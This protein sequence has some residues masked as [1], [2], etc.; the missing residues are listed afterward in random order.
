[1]ARS[2]RDPEPQDLLEATNAAKLQRIENE[3]N[4]FVQAHLDHILARIHPYLFNLAYDPY[5]MELITELREQCRFRIPWHDVRDWL[6][7]ISEGAGQNDESEKVGVVF[8]TLQTR[9]REI[10]SNVRIDEAW[11]ELKFARQKM[12]AAIIDP[13][14]LE[15]RNKDLFTIIVRQFFD[16]VR[17]SQISATL[18]KKWL[19]SWEPGEHAHPE[20]SSSPTMDEIPSG[21]GLPTRNQ[22]FENRMRN[23]IACLRQET[24][25]MILAH[26]STRDNATDAEES[27]NIQIAVDLSRQEFSRSLVL[28]KEEEDQLAA[29][30]ESSACSC[31]RVPTTSASEREGEE[32]NEKSAEYK[33]EEEALRIAIAMSL[34]DMNRGDEQ[35]SF[36]V[37]SAAEVAEGEAAVSGSAAGTGNHALP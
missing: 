2:P 6:R 30:I 37:A 28:A 4:E 21:F 20:P 3:W 1:M 8:A 15:G 10:I 26:E 12:I 29:V 13:R 27:K 24:D 17:K 16:L 35:M 14:L 22:L 7:D 25:S 34:A 36:S 18:C 23:I 31:V 33:D 32:K 11:M 9:A 19:D 5:V